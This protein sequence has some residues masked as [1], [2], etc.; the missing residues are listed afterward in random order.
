MV[1]KGIRVCQKHRFVY[2]GSWFPLLTTRCSVTSTDSLKRVLGFPVCSKMKC[3]W[4]N[5]LHHSPI[6]DSVLERQS[7]GSAADRKGV[8]TS[9]KP[10]WAEVKLIR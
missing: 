2:V 5:N 9:A 3:L 6:V 4:L 10:K 7:L 8:K 1:Q